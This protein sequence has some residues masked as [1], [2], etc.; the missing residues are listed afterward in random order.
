MFETLFAKTFTILG[1]QL[2]V[3]WITTVGFIGWVR[4]RNCI[5]HIAYDTT[6]MISADRGARRDA[7]L[8]YLRPS[9]LS[10]VKMKSPKFWKR[11]I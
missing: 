8:L 11:R 2:L 5:R 10:A 1:S 7:Y 6:L 9:S 4:H 3:T